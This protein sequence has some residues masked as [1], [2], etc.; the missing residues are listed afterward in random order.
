M[1]LGMIQKGPKEL[2][3]TE[4]AGIITNANQNLISLK[5]PRLNVSDLSLP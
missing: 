1:Y 5:Y 3:K 2:K 4:V